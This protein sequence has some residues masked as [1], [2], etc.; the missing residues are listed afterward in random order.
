MPNVDFDLSFNQTILAHQKI[1]KKK[2]KI[3]FSLL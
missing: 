2:K 3:S 1:A